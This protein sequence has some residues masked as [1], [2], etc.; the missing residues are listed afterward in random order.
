MGATHMSVPFE[1][2]REY[3]VFHR[4]DIFKRKVFIFSSWT[5]DLRQVAKR[6]REPWACWLGD[7]QLGL[8]WKIRIV[9]VFH[10]I[11]KKF[12]D[13][14]QKNLLV[15]E[16]WKQ[17]WGWKLEGKCYITRD[18]WLS[19]KYMRSSYSTLYVYLCQ[20]K[21]NHTQGDGLHHLCYYYNVCKFYRA[22]EC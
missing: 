2:M 21:R 8:P 1:Q 15:N 10:A 22:M 19:G 13:E 16:Y 7:F 5:S 6:G 9:N 12:A 4:L 20:L 17:S 11:S 3:I 18:V 14:S